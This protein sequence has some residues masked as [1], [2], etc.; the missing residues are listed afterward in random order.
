M[1][2][3]L[4]A[5]ALALTGITLTVVVLAALSASTTV[6][7]NGTINTSA[8]IEAYSDFAC[9]Q[10]V[11]ALDV[12]NVNPGS[13]VS[14]TIYIKNTGN[15]PLTLTMAAS[16]WSPTGANT[17]L[18]LSWNREDD[19][20]DASDSVSATFTLTVASDTGSLTTFSCSIT[21]TGTE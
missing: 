13:T 5:A 16:G 19:V 7:L 3:K 15:I 21:I 2:T 17:Y 18:T 9:T 8:N 11:T 14:R 4:T 1:N 10:P 20:L 6:P 12:G